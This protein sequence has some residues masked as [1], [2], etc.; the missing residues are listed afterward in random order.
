MDKS[1][2][3]KIRDNYFVHFSALFLTVF[4][5]VGKPIPYSNDFSYL[6]RLISTYNSEFLKNDLTFSAY[7]N[8][9]WLFNHLFG[10]FTLFLSIEVIGW[11]GR[12]ACWSILIALLLRLGKRWKIPLW[13]VTL[14]IFL[15]LS[16]G[17]SIVNDEW[18]FGGFEAKCVAYIFLLTALDRFCDGRDFSSAALLGLSFS[19]HPLVGLWGF[20]ASVLALIV[21]HKDLVRTGK[22]IL[23][24]AAFSLIGLIPLLIM[25]ANSVDSTSE[26][27]QYL[28]LVK[29]P[30][31]FDPFAWARSSILFLFL[32]GVFIIALH[33]RLKDSEAPSKFLFAFLVFLGSFFFAGIGLRFFDQY[34]LLE[35]MPMRLYPVFAPLFF[36]F[37]FGAACKNKIDRSVIIPVAV[38]VLIMS[39]WTKLPL[40]TYATLNS[41]YEAWTQT[42]DDTAHTFIWLRENTPSDSIVIAPP[43]RYDFWYLS[44]RARIVSYHQPIYS[45]LNEWQT[46]LEKLTGKALP[47]NGFREDEELSKFYLG[48]ATDEIKAIA[49]AYN[50]TYLVSETDYPLPLV[51]KKGNIKVFRLKEETT[52]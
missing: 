49:S 33:I 51:F 43:W 40:R 44:H 31:H 36:L 23:I 42:K 3:E 22:V 4:A 14:S 48:L 12:F 16:I 32:L 18:M 41:T 11:L 35:F 13:M 38:V 19:F 50:A 7:Q 6:L 39:V 52:K 24:G 2:L 21:F 34:A 17:Q 47:E 15:W 26:N 27:L 8:E 28:E 45:D 10:V 29:F 25:K 1:V 9:H 5:F 37:Y 30:F 20:L 46:R